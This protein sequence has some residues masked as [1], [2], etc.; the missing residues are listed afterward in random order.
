MGL[1]FKRGIQQT[2]QRLL[3]PHLVGRP[4]SEAAGLVAVEA[5]HLN[6]PLDAEVMENAAHLQRQQVILGNGPRVRHA[7]NINGKAPSRPTHHRHVVKHAAVDA[8]LVK[9][10]L[11][12][13]EADVIQPPCKNNTRAF[14]YAS[15][16]QG[17]TLQL[18]RRRRS[19]VTQSWSS[20]PF[21][22]SS[23]PRAC[24]ASCSFFRWRGCFMLSSCG[25]HDFCICSADIFRTRE[26]RIDRHLLQIVLRRLQ[27]RLSR[28]DPVV[29]LSGVQAEALL[30]Q[31]RAHVVRAPQSEGDVGGT[32]QTQRVNRGSRRETVPLRGGSDTYVRLDSRDQPS[33][34]P[35]VARTPPLRKSVSA[36][37]SRLKEVE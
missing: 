18:R 5:Q 3:V 10:A 17:P 16:R 11:V 14:S 7:P 23:E 34:G 8:G 9:V 27:Q 1:L 2:G 4:A 21:R 13:R 33:R 26:L 22:S 15:K 35:A 32:A 37:S 28:L 20:L 19:L 29:A 25:G 36:A 12:L 30:V 31:P 24:R 6:S